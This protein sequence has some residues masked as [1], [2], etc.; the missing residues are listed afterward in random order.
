MII[1]SRL[2][3]VVSFI[4]N[5][6]FKVCIIIGKAPTTYRIRICFHLFISRSSSSLHSFTTFCPF[7]IIG[8]TKFFGNQLI[9][10]K[11]VYPCLYSLSSV[12]CLFHDC[13]YL[14]TPYIWPFIV[15]TFWWQSWP[16]IC[17]NFFLSCALFYWTWGPSTIL[18][19][20]TLLMLRGVSL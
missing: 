2:H 9:T 15:I 19:T 14:Q 20:I 4:C 11:E 13:I 3:N 8:T 17:Y 5:I 16:W 12:L 1:H 6:P 7:C 10:L 18:P